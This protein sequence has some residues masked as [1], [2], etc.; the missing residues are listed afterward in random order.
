MDCSIE[1]PDGEALFTLISYF[2][3]ETESTPSESLTYIFPTP[4]KLLRTPASS[5]QGPIPL[6]VAFDAGSSIASFNSF[7][8]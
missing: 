4:S 8:E 3:D 1:V 6:S 2:E 7:Y 5:D